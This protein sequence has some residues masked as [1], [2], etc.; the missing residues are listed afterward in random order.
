MRTVLGYIAIATGMLVPVCHGQG[1]FDEVNSRNTERGGFGLYGVSVF[2]SYSPSSAGLGIPS[3]G[4]GSNVAYGASGSAGWQRHGENTNASIV[5]TGTYGGLVQDS[6]LNSYSQALSLSLSRKLAPKWSLTISAA[7]QDSTFA[8]Y[9]F[10]P[11]GLSVIS[12]L[13]TN[14]DDFAAAFGV[15]QFSSSQIASLTQQG[16]PFLLSPIRTA[17]LGDRV[18]TYSGQASV[19]Y[20]YSPRLHFYF[21]GLSAGGQNRYGQNA[22]TP[23]N[24][25]MPRTLGGNAGVGVSYSLSPRTE[26]SFDV[27]ENALWNRYQNSYGT[28]ATAS[29]GRKMGEH[30]FLRMYGGATRTQFTKQTYGSARTLQGVGGAS[31]GFKVYAQTFVGSYDLTASDSFGFAVGTNSTA[32]GTWSWHR[33]GSRTNLFSSFSRQQ[34]R[35]TGFV[36]ITA[37]QGTAGVS[38]IMTGQTSLTAQYVYLDSAAS[39]LGAPRSISVTI[40]LLKLNE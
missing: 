23:Q 5:Y 29:L 11:L 2:S 34:V 24:Y 10:Q 32:T 16:A 20:A 1:L 38:L 6:G 22:S 17:L 27:E 7:G 36:S 18:V 14:F 12:Q 37:W 40:N 21:A 30:W 31:L 15:G 19:N 3:L 28:T 13:P 33:P 8:Q 4:T 39:Y 35:N 26:M 9:L 25:V